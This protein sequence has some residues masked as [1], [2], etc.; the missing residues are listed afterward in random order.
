MGQG[1]RFG[2]ARSSA[3]IEFFAPLT[4]T[5]IFLETERLLF[6]SHAPG[7]EAY[8]VSMH[9]DAEVGCCGG[10]PAWAGGQGAVAISRAVARQADRNLRIVGDCI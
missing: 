5:M 1:W 8:F 10:G 9:F 7:D 6:W 2:L 4:G 3:E